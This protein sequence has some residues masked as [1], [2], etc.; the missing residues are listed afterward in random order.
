MA[1]RYRWNYKK[2]AKNIGLLILKL[3]GAFVL[4]VLLGAGPFPG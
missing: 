1:K 4:C 2:C 3:V